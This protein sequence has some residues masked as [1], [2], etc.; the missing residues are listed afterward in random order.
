MSHREGFTVMHAVIDIIT[1]LNV[2]KEALV[3]RVGC[4]KWYMAPR[5]SSVLSKNYHRDHNIPDV[6]NFST[7][8][9]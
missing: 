1:G 6:T 4:E 2:Y 5:P 8:E 7:R 3:S 9:A